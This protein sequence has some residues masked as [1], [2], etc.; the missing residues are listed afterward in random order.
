MVLGNG[1]SAIPYLAPPG[2]QRDREYGSSTVPPAERAEPAPGRDG[3]LRD[4]FGKAAYKNI[5]I[6]LLRYKQLRLFLHLDS[7]DRNLRD[8]Q[9]QGFV[10]LGTDYTQNYYEYRLPA[11]GDQAGR[12]NPLGRGRLAR[13][14]QP[15]SEL[16]FQEFIDAK[17]ARNRP[18]HGGR[19]HPTTC[20]PFVPG[21][22][23][24]R[25]HHHGSRQPR[26]VG[27]AGRHDW[28]LQPGRRRR[29]QDR[30]ALGR[31][32]PGVRVR[33]RERLGGHGPLQHQASPTWPT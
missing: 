4:G 2:I 19:Q 13:R 3:N 11:E 32:V 8:G 15:D 18:G 27:R 1:S 14:S 31:R 16:A 12:H 29:G 26:P 20:V 23:A 30:H 10:R 28:P 22:F 33:P 21:P 25:R 24:Q 6:S 7:Q 9:L 17:A 5:Q